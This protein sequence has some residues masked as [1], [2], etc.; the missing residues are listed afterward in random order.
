M[1]RFWWKA[2]RVPLALAVLVLGAGLALGQ[3]DAGADP[4][5]QREQATVPVVDQVEEAEPTPPSPEEPQPDTALEQPPLEEVQPGTALKQPPAERPPKAASEPAPPPPAVAPLGPQEG[6]GPDGD[7]EA[8]AKAPPGAEQGATPSSEAAQPM[9]PP[10]TARAKEALDSWRFK[11]ITAFSVGGLMT[12]YAMS[13]AGAVADANAGQDAAIDLIGDTT[14][15]SPTE[16]DDLSAE[17]AAYAS[18]ASQHKGSADIGVLVAA[19][20]L[21]YGAWV[22]FQE[23]PSNPAGLV[24]LPYL[25]QHR[26]GVI[27]AARW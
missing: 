9:P 7:L 17:V 10:L 26:R 20:A 1:T 13:E 19:T 5:G 4:P 22:F 2:R 24:V 27:V 12:L 16:F 14:T 8:A 25:D 23:D 21:G 11:W 6:R 15:I 3:E 18:A